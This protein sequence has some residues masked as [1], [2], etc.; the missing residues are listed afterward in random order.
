MRTTAA[1][2]AALAL[3]AA[4]AI[5]AAAAAPAPPAPAGGV[6]LATVGLDGWTVQSTRVVTQGGDQVSTPG[7]PTGEW[8]AVAP[9]D[10]GAPGTEMEAMLQNGVCPRDPSFRVHG[11]PAL[12]D[13]SVLFSDNMQRCFGLMDTIGPDTIPEFSVPWWFRADFAADPRPG[14]AASIVVNGI[15]GQADVWVNGVEVGTQASVRGSFTR[16]AFDVTD[17]LRRG[18]NSLALELFPNDPTLMLTEDTV[19]WNQIPLDNSTGIQFP[20]QLHLSRALAVANAYVTQD[21]APDLSSAALTVHADVTNTTP[22]TQSGVVE[23]AVESP[24]GGAPIR[25]SRQ[26][27]VPAGAT[28]TV[29]FTPSA[30]PQLT[31]QRPRVW[32]PY[33][34]GGQPLYRLRVDVA[35]GGT[36]S[37]TAPPVTFGIRTITT[38]LTPPSDLAPQ[39]VRWFAVNGRVIVFRAG[40]F[41]EDLFLH[42]SAAD[43]A[44]QVALIRSMGLNGIRTEG[45][46]VP[47]DFYERMDRAGILVDAGFQCC[48]KWQPDGDGRGVTAEDFRVMYQ[49]SLAIGERLRDHPS[50][51]GYSWSDSPPIPEQ[52]AASLAGF[53]QAGFEGPMISSAESL[54]TGLLG[55]SGEREGPYDWVPPAYWYD[56]THTSNNAVDN[57]PGMTNVGGSWGFDSE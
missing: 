22:F 46:E 52:E 47:G 35:Q 40:G 54:R 3:W 17:L 18:V 49:S 24:G 53:A 7:F 37:D 56:T 8:L 27:T 39:G 10:A 4:S 36:V 50:V 33:Q 41:V 25:V 26:V 44:N 42:Y 9:D 48:D 5:P 16:F 45:K 31:I 1:A 30:L 28:Q 34:L 2:M 55:P 15:V 21:D 12:D 13:H 20:V 29:T 38:F 32:W 14:Q 23:A 6:G 43:V 19:D 51:M 11:G 57:D